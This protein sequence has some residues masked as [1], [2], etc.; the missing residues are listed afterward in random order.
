MIEYLMTHMRQ[1]MDDLTYRDFLG[2]WGDV[3]SDTEKMQR[4]VE[5]VRIC[6]GVTN[7]ESIKARFVEEGRAKEERERSMNCTQASVKV[8]VVQ[9][10][11]EIGADLIVEDDLET[12]MRGFE[13]VLNGILEE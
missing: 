10:K 9:F 13:V 12:F 7:Y 5:T 2:R 4:W 8:P 1:Y 11:K 3:N 6:I